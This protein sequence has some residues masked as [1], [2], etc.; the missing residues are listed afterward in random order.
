MNCY[1]DNFFKLKELSILIPQV[2]LNDNS[3]TKQNHGHVKNNPGF[4]GLHL[5]SEIMNGLV[6]AYKH[7]SF[8]GEFDLL[9]INM[10]KYLPV[11]QMCS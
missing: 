8:F 1:I 6:A 5:T 3:H 7:F 10:T 4:L 11:D 9:W 2:K